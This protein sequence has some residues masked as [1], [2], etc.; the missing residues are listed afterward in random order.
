MGWVIAGGALQVVGFVLVA[1]DLGRTQHR[2]FGVPTWIERLRAF[3]RRLFRHTKTVEIGAVVATATSTASARGKV[4]TPPGESHAARLAALEKNFGRLDEEVEENRAAADR[5]RGELLEQLNVTR[6][7]VNQQREMDDQ[8]RKAFL[9][10]SVL[11]QSWGTGFFVLGTV[12]GVIR[13][14]G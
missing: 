4:R 7:E 8:E 1:V 5:W 12:L 6:A 11:L 14:V 2:E 9:R 10:T 3:L 13:A